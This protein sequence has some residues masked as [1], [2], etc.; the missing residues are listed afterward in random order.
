M[1][2]DKQKRC[3][4]FIESELAD[5]G[6]VFDGGEDGHK[7]FEFISLNLERANQHQLKRWEEESKMRESK[8]VKIGG[9]SKGHIYTGADDRGDIGWVKR[10]SDGTYVNPGFRLWR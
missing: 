9:M 8:T 1:I 3:I 10:Q 5:D 7:A 6:V 2:T 4:R